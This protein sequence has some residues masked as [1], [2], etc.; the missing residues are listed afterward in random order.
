[1]PIVDGDIFHSNQIEVYF[2][3]LYCD[4]IVIETSIGF[5]V[6]TIQKKISNQYKKYV[7]ETEEKH[8]LFFVVQTRRSD[9][10]SNTIHTR[11]CEWIRKQNQFIVDFGKRFVSMCLCVFVRVCVW[12]LQTKFMIGF[13]YEYDRL[14]WYKL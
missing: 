7:V 5:M 11:I 1:M 6:K 8:I 12:A 13:R 14:L 3:W 2:W 9:N 10:I 4:N